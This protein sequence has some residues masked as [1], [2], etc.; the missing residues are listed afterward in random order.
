MCISKQ[1]LDTKLIILKTHDKESMINY[2]LYSEIIILK[3]ESW[4]IVKN[5]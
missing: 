3:R 2:N 1:I 5:L 4:I